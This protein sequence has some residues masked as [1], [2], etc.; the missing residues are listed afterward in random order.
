MPNFEY[1][2]SNT[3][4]QLVVSPSEGTVFGNNL[5][6]YIRITIYPTEAIGNI[7]TLPGTDNQA[8]FYSSG[9]AVCMLLRSLILNHSLSKPEPLFLFDNHYS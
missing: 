6:D 1:E 9:K 4:R 5:T 7:V 2:F 8:I 3:D